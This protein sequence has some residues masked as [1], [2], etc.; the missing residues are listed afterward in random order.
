VEDEKTDERDLRVI[1]SRAANGLDPLN[2]SNDRFYEISKEAKRVV[3]QTFGQL[4][5]QHA[6]PALKLQLPFVKPICCVSTLAES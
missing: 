1:A 6:Y 4:E 2:L 3:R 5:V